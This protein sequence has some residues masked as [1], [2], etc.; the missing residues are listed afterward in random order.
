MHL[1]N[2]NNWLEYRITVRIVY[3]DIFC[4]DGAPVIF[5]YVTQQFV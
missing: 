1:V 3:Y 4:V 5:L 2:D